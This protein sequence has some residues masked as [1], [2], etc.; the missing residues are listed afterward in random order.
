MLLL[1]TVCGLVS[2]GTS[3]AI[4]RDVL[5]HHDPERI[6]LKEKRASSSPASRSRALPINLLN[7]LQERERDEAETLKRSCH[8]DYI[9]DPKIGQGE[10]DEESRSVQP[11]HPAG[12]SD[13]R[14]SGVRLSAFQG[15]KWSPRHRKPRQ[16][17]PDADA[18]KSIPDLEQQPQQQRSRPQEDRS[19]GRLTDDKEDLPAE[20]R[21]TQEL[22][23]NHRDLKQQEQRQ[24]EPQQQQQRR[25]QQHPHQQQQLEQQKPHEDKDGKKDRKRTDFHRRVDPKKDNPDQAPVFSSYEST[26]GSFALVCGRETGVTPPANLTYVM[27]SLLHERDVTHHM[28]YDGSFWPL[29]VGAYAE[30]HLGRMAATG[31]CVVIKRFLDSPLKT[32][33][34]EIRIHRYVESVLPNTPRLLGVLPVGLSMENTSLVYQNVPGYT[35][36]DFRKMEVVSP[37]QVL[38]V[39]L[40][41]ATSLEA[42]HR[43][44]ILHN[45][46]HSSNVLIRFDPPVPPVRRTPGQAD[47]DL[48]RFEKYD[49]DIDGR[50]YRSFYKVG[51]WVLPQVDFIDFGH[52]TYRKGKVYVGSEQSLLSCHHLAPEATRNQ[53]TTPAAD[54]F[55]L[56]HELEFLAHNLNRTVLWDLVHE[57]LAHDPSARPPMME[58]ID[59]LQ[60]MFLNEYRHVE[61]MYLRTAEARTR[62][63]LLSRAVR[64]TDTAAAFA[65]RP[66]GEDTREECRGDLRDPS[67]ACGDSLPRQEEGATEGW[68]DRVNEAD[69]SSCDP[70]Y[71]G[72]TQRHFCEDRT[73]EFVNSVSSLDDEQMQ[74]LRRSVLEMLFPKPNDELLRQRKESLS[75]HRALPAAVGQNPEQFPASSG[76]ARCDSDAFERDF[77]GWT[78]PLFL[79]H[80]G[81]L[82]FQDEN[83]TR[84]VILETEGSR[85]FAGHFKSS[86]QEVVI[87]QKRTDDYFRVRFE[88]LVHMHLNQTGRVP[89]FYGVVPLSRSRLQKLGIVQER[90]ADGVTLERVL[91]SG[92]PTGGWASRLRLALRLT[93]ALHDVHATH[94]LINNVRAGNILCSCSRYGLDC[95]DVRFVDLGDAS[96]CEGKM[97]GYG[98][99]GYDSFAP[100][101]RQHRKTSF[102]SDAYSLCVLLRDVVP[103][104]GAEL[105]SAESDDSVGGYRVLSSDGNGSEVVKDNA[106]PFD[107]ND[108]S[109]VYQALKKN[110]NSSEKIKEFGTLLS[111]W[112]TLYRLCLSANP[113]DRPSLFQL[114]HFF[115]TFLKSIE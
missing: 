55:S 115:A 73:S 88:A 104:D 106:L 20:V 100:E 48:S 91:D 111:R 1:L 14:K 81:D 16:P 77:S 103:I 31:E 79:S 7:Y 93:S 105:F 2:P 113:S 64:S 13:N 8:A 83:L 97:Y 74:L 59:R 46:F 61:K 108:G 22:P 43:K 57:C 10:A 17:D 54:V 114:K 36:Y 29:G 58:V 37:L 62:V 40:Q 56:G 23:D 92:M 26:L 52:A 86:G 27:T 75:S 33:E 25:Q 34:R 12:E 101:V 110:R 94:T 69:S 87:K 39:A 19:H 50:L 35:L 49:E 63:P 28:T 70:L 42:L 4:H 5:T 95:S 99:A 72:P 71:A 3:A 9:H 51:P 45:D 53:E 21:L 38:A 84:T 32:I 96:G 11:R 24:N 80:S 15:T 65:A 67:S 85:F 41:M 18:R 6:E 109:F 47:C 89:A 60:S 98:P 78:L 102:A 90:F 68:N 66:R 107:N 112:G 76:T 44:C 82:F 30:V